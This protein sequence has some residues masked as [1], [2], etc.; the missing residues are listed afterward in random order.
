MQSDQTSIGEGLLYRETFDQG[1]GAWSTG[2]DQEDGSWHRNILGFRGHPV[3]LSWSPDGGRSG[4]CAYAEPPWYF[5]DNH[6][7]FAWLY[8]LFFADR[9]ALLGLG[10]R[11]LR[12]A[13]IQVTLRGDQFELKGS[14]LY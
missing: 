14:K 13:T 1:P 5:D 2:K 12:G 4:G 6:G 8:L 10:G 3:P 9:S 7:E 11:D